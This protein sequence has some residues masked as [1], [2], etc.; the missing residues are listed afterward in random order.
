MPQ[1]GRRQRRGSLPEIETPSRSV[2]SVRLLFRTPT[3]TAAIAAAGDGSVEDDMPRPLNLTSTP[4]DGTD[5]Y[6]KLGWDDED[7]DV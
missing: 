4:A 5:L 7:E 3:K 6:A 1:T 2:K